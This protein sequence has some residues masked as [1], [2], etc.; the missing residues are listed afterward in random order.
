[1]CGVSTSVTSTRWWW[2]S[3][4]DGST[5][6]VGYDTDRAVGE[7]DDRRLDNDD[8]MGGLDLKDGSSG[9]KKSRKVN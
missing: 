8:D 3:E 9:G 4:S 1:M 2:W 6:V 5:I 7:C